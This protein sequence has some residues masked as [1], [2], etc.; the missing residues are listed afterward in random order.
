LREGPI[1]RQRRG[2]LTGASPV[3]QTERVSTSRPQVTRQAKEW[4]KGR[5]RGVFEAGQ[6]LGVDVLPR[7]F[8]SEIPDIRDLKRNRRWQ[9]PYS[10]VGVRGTD[11]EQ[12]LAW[13][14]E[15]C[16][17]DVAN[18]LQ[19]LD[20][21]QRAAVANGALGY[22]KIEA[23]IL[24]SVVYTRRPRRMIQVGAGASTWI[25]LEA[26][27]DAGYGIQITC[28]D[29]YPTDFLQQLS[30][31]GKITLRHAPVQELAI[32]ELTDLEPGDIFFV[33]STHTVSIGSDVN[34]LILE[35]FPRLPKGTLAHL[36]DITMPFDYFPYAL[37]SDLFFW[38]ESVLLHAFLIDNPRFEI[39]LGCAMLHEVAVAEVQQIIPTYRSPV[40]TDR[41]LAVDDNVGEFPSSMW[42]E[43]VQDPSGS[44]Q[45]ST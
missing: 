40:K 3:W 9:R 15:S 39:R 13:L 19:S 31:D 23:D 27:K 22:G 8:Y 30:S 37:S 12:Q 34:Y 10:L 43:V 36:H 42:L 20:L 44:A 5:L 6:H 32:N 35:V 14:R 11:T 7:H 45:P 17:P 21:Q 4:A 41:G 2:N 26:A 25:A 28:V 1:G 16:P 29:P 24:Y 33:D 38:T 18:R